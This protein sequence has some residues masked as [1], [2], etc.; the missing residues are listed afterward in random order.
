[1]RTKTKLLFKTIVL[2]VLVVSAIGC[3]SN[4]AWYDVR[5]YS[6]YNPFRT[7][8]HS[9]RDAPAVA[10]NQ[11]V[12]PHIDP[13]VDVKQPEGGYYDQSKNTSALTRNVGNSAGRDEIQQT[14]FHS[15]PLHGGVTPSPAVNPYGY[16]DSYN[17]G[18]G[19]Y[20]NGIGGAPSA[21][22]SGYTPPT[23]FNQPTGYKVQPSAEVKNDT[24]GLP[25]PYAALNNAAGNPAAATY[26]YNTS[27]SPNPYVAAG[28]V[29]P[30]VAGPFTNPT[31]QP[32]TPASPTPNGNRDEC[33]PPNGQSLPVGT[34]VPVAP[35]YSGVSA[36]EGSYAGKPVAPSY[37]GQQT[38]NTNPISTGQNH[39]GNAYGS[40]GIP[41]TNG[42][43]YTNPSIY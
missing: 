37:G 28:G 30:A 27:Y 19:G 6:L 9:H 38:G 23:G 8:D 39:V 22:P 40:N 32:T 31:G 21:N 3:R 4:G 20:N 41:T 24:S 17:S 36:A 29:N 12:K 26:N 5:S 16:P 7:E 2:V 34:S 35:I 10:D 1:M 13:R 11:L 18:T 15:D 43:V 25:N 42:N 33:C 14:S